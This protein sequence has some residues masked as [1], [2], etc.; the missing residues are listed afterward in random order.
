MCF[1]KDPFVCPIG[2]GIRRS[3]PILFGWDWNPQ[4]FSREGSGSLGFR[5]N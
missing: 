2:K 4:S 5:V 1:P 3:I